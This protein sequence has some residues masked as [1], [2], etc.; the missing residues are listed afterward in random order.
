MKLNEQQIEQLYT[1]TCQHFVEWYDLQTE[2]VDHLANAIEAEW[3]QNPKLTFE[4]AL[5]L[6]FKKFGV[7]GFMDVVEKRQAVLNKKYNKLVLNELKNFF[8]VPKIIVTFSA[9]AIVFYLLKSF[10]EG[11]LIMQ[12]AF[13]LS[14]VV[15]FIG[16]WMLS[17][18]IKRNNEETGKKWLFK[19]IIFGYGSF[20][21]LINL[22]IQLA[23]NLDGHNYPELVLMLLSF[24]LIVL[25][26]LE[27]IV[28]VLIPSKAEEYLHAT[29]PEYEI[30]N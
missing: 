27:Y 5:H 25:V 2:L 9:I 3:Q 6:E 11:L 23:I 29:Y 28:L 4:E 10:Q 22:P 7:F 19:D 20:T 26:L 17:R 21:G 30:K 18:K 12:I 14:A 24:L 1:F 8:S 13:I 16:L 15:C